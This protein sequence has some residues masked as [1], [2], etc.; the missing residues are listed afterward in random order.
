MTLCACPAAP[1]GQVA[2]D[3]RST[4][5]R[6]LARESV[7]R[8]ARDGRL[9]A[10]A[11]L[12]PVLALEVALPWRPPA[13][14][15]RG[16]RPDRDYIPR[17]PAVGVRNGSE[18]ELLKLG[19]VVSNRSIRRYRWRGP[20]GAP[21]QTWRTFLRNHA[22]HIWAADLLSVPTLT[23]KTLHVLVFIA[24][25]R[26]ELVH[27]NVKANRPQPGS[28]G[29]SSR[30]RRGAANPAICS[31]IAMPSMAVTFASALGASV[32]MRSPHPST[33]QRPTPSPNGSSGHCAENVWTTSSCWTSSICGRCWPEFVRYYNQERPHRTLGLQTPCAE[34]ASDDRGRPL[35][36]SVERTTPRLRTCRL[37]TTEVSPPH[38]PANCLP[39]LLTY[40]S[41]RRRHD[42]DWLLDHHLADHP[43]VWGARVREGAGGIKCHVHRLADA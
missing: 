25:G 35:A 9:L 37:T 8:D 34:S 20:G 41:R 2:V 21:A 1:L 30:P 16:A 6:R 40:S 36:S 42:A 22:H 5:L 12:A 17:Q 38:R 28:G 43:W 13:S 3:R 26:R 7:V 24:H 4:V 33:R 14:H 29:N 23:F 15:P 10:S 27:V 11:G 19:I 39:V 32:S 18:G 31:M